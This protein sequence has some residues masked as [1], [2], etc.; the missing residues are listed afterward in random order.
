MTETMSPEQYLAY[1]AKPKKRSK[2]GSEKTEV[3]GK[4]FHSKKEAKRYGIL[5]IME[6]AG[7]IT[8]LELQPE[9]LIEVKGKKVA[10]Y[11]ADF[12]YRK[13]GKTVVEDVKSKA[14]RLKANYRL[15]KKCVEAQYG[16][17]IIE[18]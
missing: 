10:K 5:R 12:R 1:L 9:F 14:T 4:S 18:T 16:I 11:S 15:K 3:D 17:E 6:L 7:E 2:Y 8:D 13:D